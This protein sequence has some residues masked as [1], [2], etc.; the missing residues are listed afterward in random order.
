MYQ[1]LKV[2]SLSVNRCV[3]TKTQKGKHNFA[4]PSH[5]LPESKQ[6]YNTEYQRVILHCLLQTVTQTMVKHPWQCETTDIAGPTKR[7]L[8]DFSFFQPDV[9][10]HLGNVGLDAWE[11]STL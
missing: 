3:A 5:C 4:V 8:K 9:R 7:S 1:A 10:S 6:N 2:Q 11:A